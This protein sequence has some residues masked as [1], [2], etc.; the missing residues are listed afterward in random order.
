MIKKITQRPEVSMLAKLISFFFLST[1][2]LNA[3]ADS[4]FLRAFDLKG[5]V[6]T[7]TTTQT[8]ADDSDIVELLEF[9]SN[10]KLIKFGDDYREFSYSEM[11][12]TT[13]T[14]LQLGIELK[15]DNPSKY[16]ARII[17]NYDFFFNRDGKLIK[18][19]HFI[20]ESMLIDNEFLPGKHIDENLDLLYTFYDYDSKGNVSKIYG[21]VHDNKKECKS[22]TVANLKFDSYGNWTKRSLSGK[23]EDGDAFTIIQTRD[24]SYWTHKTKTSFQRADIV[25]FGIKH[26]FTTPVGLRL[27]DKTIFSFNYNPAAFESYIADKV[28]YKRTIDKNG[29]YVFSWNK[30][31]GAWDLHFDK[32]EV[33]IGKQGGL[34]FRD[35]GKMIVSYTCNSKSNNLTP[36]AIFNKLVN[37]C[38]EANFGEM[39]ITKSKAEFSWYSKKVF[40]PFLEIEIVNTDVIF[41]FYDISLSNEK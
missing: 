20:N 39:S 2:S 18:T 36:Q 9:D 29:N 13:D 19:Y 21:G 33:T 31:V 4:I 11:R 38:R 34:L 5:P 40:Y 14:P 41:S 16:I 30:R 28:S 7:C 17:E 37:I 27:T 6:K 10:G 32:C 3:F 23:D 8:V 1:L 26:F 22:L 25:R 15:K 35:H 24:I 12:V